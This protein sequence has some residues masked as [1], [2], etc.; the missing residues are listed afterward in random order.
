MI[1]GFS[2]KKQSGKN[3]SCNFCLGTFLWQNGIIENTYKINP[4]GKLVITDLFGDT[5][6]SGILDTS[7]N[8]PALQEFLAKNINHICKIYSFADILKREVCINILGLSEESCYGSD[9]E[10]DRPT[11][12]KWKD[13]PGITTKRTPTGVIDEEQAEALNQY[14]KEALSEISYHSPGPMTG[15]EVMQFVGTNIFRKMYGDVWVDA[16]MRKIKRD[17]VQFALV[18]DIRFPNEVE[19]IQ[20]NGGIV[21]RL[22]KNPL[23]DQH[24]SETALDDFYAFDFLLDNKSMTIEEQNGH[25]MRILMESGIP[26]VCT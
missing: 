11:H 15:R 20:K 18:A 1:I 5:K 14:Y 23:D 6:A 24:S 2:G 22:T 16:L 25:L 9:E 3:T 21:I 26:L 17:G 19:S 8:D 4:A 7:R 13:M 12:L 10:K